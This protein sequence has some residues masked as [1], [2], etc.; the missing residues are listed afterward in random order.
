[1]FKMPCLESSHPLGLPELVSV[2]C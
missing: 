1:M 2:L